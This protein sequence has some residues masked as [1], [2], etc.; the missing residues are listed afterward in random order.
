MVRTGVFATEEEL[1]DLQRLSAR[2]WRPGDVMI[3][4]SVMEG[5]TKDQ[6]TVDARLTCHRLALAHGL[7]EIQ[8]Y[9]GIMKD[10]EFVRTE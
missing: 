3:V 6:S 7:P 2:G 5:I 10:G 9:Y 1:E 4:T 8:G